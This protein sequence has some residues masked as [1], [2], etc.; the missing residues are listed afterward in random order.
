MNCPIE[1]VETLERYLKHGT[2]TGGF[3]HACLTNNLTESFA[4]ADDYN[5]AAMFGIVNYMYNEL[6]SDCWG[7]PG[8]VEAWLDKKAEERKE[9]ES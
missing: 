2:P 1:V 3:L 9:N 5:R 7:S 4:L 6:P 8:K